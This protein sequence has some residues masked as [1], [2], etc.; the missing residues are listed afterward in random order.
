MHRESIRRPLDVTLTRVP[1]PSALAPHAPRGLVHVRIVDTEAPITLD[2]HRLRELFALT[3]REQDIACLLADGY[4]LCEASDVLCVSQQTVRSHLKQIFCKT[5]THR[6][7]ALIRS[8]I[9]C[10]AWPSP[11]TP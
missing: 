2:R 6:Q 5:G 8:L 3:S 4:S 7:A 9:Q 10:A 11:T 1:C